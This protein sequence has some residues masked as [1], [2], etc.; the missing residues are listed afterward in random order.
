MELPLSSLGLLLPLHLYYP[1]NIQLI[2]FSHTHTL[3]SSAPTL[4]IQG[5]LSNN[6]VPEFGF[7]LLYFKPSVEGYSYCSLRKRRL[8]ELVQSNQ[9]R[10][11]QRLCL[12]IIVGMW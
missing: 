12:G 3:F 11:G 8:D 5:K 7:Q 10:F 9:S 4:S 2:P 6:M 1:L